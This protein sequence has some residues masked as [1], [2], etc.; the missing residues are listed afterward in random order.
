MR[1]HDEYFNYL[2]KCVRRE[3]ALKRSADAPCSLTTGDMVKGIKSIVRT[4]PDIH[5]NIETS[6]KGILYFKNRNFGWIIPIK[7]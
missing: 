5:L 4:N 1:R 6:P 7:R 3:W 2:D